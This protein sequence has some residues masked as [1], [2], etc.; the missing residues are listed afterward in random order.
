VFSTL[1]AARELSPYGITPF[2][3]T[4]IRA[5][6]D[7]FGVITVDEQEDLLKVIIWVD[8]EYR[9]MLTKAHEMEIQKEQEKAAMKA[10]SSGSRSS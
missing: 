5:V 7:M 9:K 6:S 2:T 1:N 3:P 10:K 8:I 4:Q